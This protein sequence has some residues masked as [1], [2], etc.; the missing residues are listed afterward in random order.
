M[1]VKKFEA[2]TMKEA[3][4]MV[5]KQLGPE[6]I[7]LSAK[8]NRNR[9]G[10][11]GEGSVEIT[12]AISS[13]TLRKKQ[14]TESKM[15]ENSKQKFQNAGAKSQKRIMEEFVNKYVDKQ[16][17]DQ[18]DEEEDLNGGQNFGPSQSSR[19]SSKGGSSVSNS[20]S[21]KR[22]IDIDENPVR[23]SGYTRQA[24]SIARNISAD[25]EEVSENV[26]ESIS[27]VAKSRIRSAAQRALGAFQEPNVDFN[28]TAAS[29]D[30][31]SV[32]EIRALHSEIET[33]KKMLS[34]FQKTPDNSAIAFPGADF[35]LQFHSSATFSK[36]I[37]QGVAPAVAGEILR[38]I[39]N[40]VPAEKGN[41]SALEGLTVRY[42]LQSIPTAS[43]QKDR[44]LQLFLGPPGS[45]KTSALIKIASQLLV[46]QK[47]KIALVT[48]DT[49]R[50]GAAEQLRIYAQILNVPFAVVRNKADWSILLS[51][52]HD[53][54]QILCDFA[55]NDLRNEGEKA[56]L[57]ELMP[58]FHHQYQTHLVLRLSSKDQEVGE[59][60][61]RYADFKPSDLIFNGLDETYSH[62]S[63]I[64]ITHKTD[65]PI[66]SF[67]TGPRVPEDYEDASTARIVDLIFHLSPQ[68]NS[69]EKS[70]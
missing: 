37:A 63:I 41:A 65:I 29:S 8:D 56:K 61:E 57:S 23:N 39:Q 60:V 45:G 49:Q 25:S 19:G 34:Q 11:V 32:L 44:K 22:Y 9:F 66:R 6:A 36:M 68:Y 52:L 26:S 27:T 21:S 55:G 53:Y 18:I 59:L 58:E 14:F 62:G 69:Q 51:R 24:T 10:L 12:A 31:K 43:P 47:K 5:K 67:G 33:L 50:I 7:I 2:R 38:L 70:V 15:N 4:E 64:N 40:Q 16:R 54:D 28:E 30:P 13:E 35:G 48:T 46:R 17:Q 20:S 1:Q 42:L 3:L